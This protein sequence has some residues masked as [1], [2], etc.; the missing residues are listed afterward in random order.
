LVFLF[1]FAKNEADNITRTEH[2]ALGKLG[3]VYL[4]YDDSTIDR[5]VRE[6]LM[7]EVAQ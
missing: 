5:M 1:G 3:D 7:I 6:M 2:V 4:A